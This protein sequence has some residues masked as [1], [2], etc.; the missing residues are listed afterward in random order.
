MR[1]RERKQKRS[2]ME[3]GT[4]KYKRECMRTRRKGKSTE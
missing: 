1:E 3:K 2:V 4:G